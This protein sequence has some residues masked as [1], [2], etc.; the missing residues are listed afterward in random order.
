MPTESLPDLS[1][2]MCGQPAIGVASTS[3]PYSAAYCREC[4][5]RGCDP[6]WIFHYWYDDVST[7]GEGMADWVIEC[8][9]SYMDGKYISWPEFVQ[10]RRDNGQGKSKPC[11][12]P[13]PLDDDSEP[14]DMTGL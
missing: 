13:P 8:A 12:P 7:D 11:E 5:S 4:A 9:T 14:L 2:E 3:V 10:W 6:L 1:C